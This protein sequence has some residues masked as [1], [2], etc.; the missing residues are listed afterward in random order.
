MR[1]EE[2]NFL[3]ADGH[4]SI[5]GVEWIPDGKA[6]AIII[7]LHGVTENIMRYEK[8]AQYFTEKN[9]VVAGAE[10]LGH[11]RSIGQSGLSMYFGPKGSWNWI[12]EDA[13]TTYK[14]IKKKYSERNIPVIFFGFSLGS[15][16]LRD[17]MIRYPQD[18]STAVIAGT[19][20]TNAAILT[21]MQGIVKIQE[22]LH[23][24]K[25]VT[26]LIKAL[27]FG[28][29]NKHF[30][31][32]RTE[33]DW[34][35]ANESELDKY[36]ADPLRGEYMTVGLF[37]ELLYGM[38]RTGSLENIKRGN[39]EV[40]VLFLSGSEDA[41]GDFAKGVQA[42]EKLF[43]KA[44]YKDIGYKIFPEMR[45]DVLH[46]KNSSEVLDYIRNWIEK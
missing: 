16:V 4:T 6:R 19:G 38:K 8:F 35:C 40:P 12:V 46:E 37:R 36:I 9:Y 21:I 13:H 2:F 1:Q 45:H 7:I 43:E 20:Q 23:G 11:G 27:T 22:I 15:F 44:G 25:T 28:T 29:Y 41:V 10:H 31:P 34:L 30:A 5:H 39:I 3:S 32:N 18:L 24:E 14:Y 42:A 26:S 33:Y 17:Y